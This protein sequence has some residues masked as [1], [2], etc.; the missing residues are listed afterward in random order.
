MAIKD[1]R[2]WLKLLEK[3]GEVRR[4]KEQVDWNVELGVITRMILSSD[5]PALLFENIKDYQETFC[6]KLFTASMGSYRR[7][8][9]MLGLPK[10]T[11]ERD[12]VIAVRDG[13]RKRLDP[14]VV[15]GGPIKENVLKGDRVNL[16]DI[17]V[18][19]WHH[20]DGGRYINTFHAICTMDPGARTHNVGMYRGM[21]GDRNH[22]PSLVVPAQHW[23]QHYT[24]PAR[25]PPDMPVAVVYGADPLLL[26]LALSPVAHPGYSEYD[27]WGGISGEPMELVKCET[28]DILVPANAEIVIEGRISYDPKN[29]IM[30]GP[31]AEHTGYYGGAQ[32]KKPAIEVDCITYRNDPIFQ[33]SCESIRPGWY[34][35]DSHSMSIAQSANAWSNLIQAGV[36]GVTDV[37]MNQSSCYFNAYVQIRKTYR[38]QAK[39]IADVLW[40]MGAAQWAFKNVFVT[41]EDIDIRNLEELDWAFATRVNAAHGD[42]VMAP[43]QFGSVLDPSTPLEER[44]VTTYG[45]GKWTRVLF[46]MTRNWDFKRREAWNMGVYPPVCVLEKEH[47]EKVVQRWET[48]GLGD[49]K[50]KPTMRI[51]RDEDL[52]YRYSLAFRPT[53]ELVK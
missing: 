37:W 24:S 36:P 53:P 52:K 3:E 35:E 20:W 19:R 8:A 9:L 4:I 42:I 39:Q 5:G 26:F 21:I 12:L 7:I 23:G 30:E 43:G 51:D 34:N 25:I 11:S 49:I 27:I 46:D 33:G 10:N 41:E 47:E 22:I 14:K 1:L 32:S 48:L 6:R 50:Y 17:P 38:G 13:Y 28:S 40:G 18:P 16:Y 44:D 2:E 15:K 29:Y 45:S 31:F